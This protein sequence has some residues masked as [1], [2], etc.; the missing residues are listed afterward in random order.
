MKAQMFDAQL[1][2]A[3]HL[4]GSEMVNFFVEKGAKLDS[5]VKAMNSLVAHF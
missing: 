4:S 5:T 2:K 1:E 3:R